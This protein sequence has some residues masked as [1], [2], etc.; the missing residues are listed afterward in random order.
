MFIA[1]PCRR[2]TK[3]ESLQAALTTDR[4]RQN[5]VTQ[6]KGFNGA[7]PETEG[8]FIQT[9]N[10]TVYLNTKQSQWGGEEGRNRSLAHLLA[11]EAV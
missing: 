5:K 3:Q 9:C 6:A 2:T 1:A 11:V 7:K 8:D 4:K 10:R